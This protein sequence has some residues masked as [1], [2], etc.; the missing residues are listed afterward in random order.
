MPKSHADW[1]IINAMR[2]T[3]VELF[4]L[5]FSPKGSPKK[6]LSVGIDRDI[7]AR[8]PTLNKAHVKMFLGAYVGGPKYLSALTEGAERI[9]L[10]GN[11]VGTVGAEAARV[12]AVRLA[13]HYERHPKREV[14]A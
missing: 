8:A 14:A 12:A 3:L 5:A 13:Y 1:K 6:P 7:I 2:V 11:V 9:D 10:D 4:P